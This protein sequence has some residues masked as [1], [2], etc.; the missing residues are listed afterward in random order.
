MTTKDTI[1]S[2]Y[3]G[4]MLRVLVHIQQ[5]LDRDLLQALNS[6]GGDLIVRLGYDKRDA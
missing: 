2:D 3:A 5:N 4:R 6:R 1:Q